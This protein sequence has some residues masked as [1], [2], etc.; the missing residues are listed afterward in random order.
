[1]QRTVLVLATGCA[2][3]LAGCQ[4]MQSSDAAAVEVGAAGRTW[5]EAFNSCNATGAGALYQPDAVLWGTF[6]RTI[7][8]GRS[9]VQQYF[10]RVCQANPPPKVALGEQ[11]LL[12][13]YG[14]TAIASGTYTFNAV[15]Q[16]QPVAIPARY[17]FTYRKVSGQWLIADHHSSA[18]P[19]APAAPPA[20]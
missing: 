8:S 14:D 1:M 11:P 19:A 10:E 9:G 6:A 4:T 20:R 12:R 3:G 16:G 18:L 13:V 17:S 2:V 5:A 7:I 15:S